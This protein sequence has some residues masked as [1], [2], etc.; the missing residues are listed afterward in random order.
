MEL[1]D[2][3]P[4]WLQNLYFDLMSFLKISEYYDDHFTF[5][6]ELVNHE[7]QFKIFCLD[8]AHFI[9][10]K[11]DFGKGSVLFSATLSPVQYYQNL[12]VDIQTI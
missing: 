4:T 2:E 7:L 5:L 6:V 11:L 1:K 10:Q 12:L 9:K 8:P 3:I